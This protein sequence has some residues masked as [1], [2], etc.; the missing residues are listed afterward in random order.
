MGCK[1]SRA[2]RR[3]GRESTAL[4]VRTRATAARSAVAATAAQE[5][6]AGAYSCASCAVSVRCHVARRSR[7][8]RLSSCRR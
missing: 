8:S 7:I 4:R 1:S 5:L 3:A 6:M 2:S